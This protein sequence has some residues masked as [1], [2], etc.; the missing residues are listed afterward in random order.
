MKKNYQSPFT[1]VVDLACDNF[2]IVASDVD[3]VIK[4]GLEDE[5]GAAI[6]QSDIEDFGSF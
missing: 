2:L 5:A 6:T 3:K 4:F 1:K